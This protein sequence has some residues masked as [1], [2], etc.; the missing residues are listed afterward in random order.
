MNETVK[1]LS[2][3]E[4]AQQIRDDVAAFLEGGPNLKAQSIK[5]AKAVGL[6]LERVSAQWDEAE[7]YLLLTPPAPRKPK[8]IEPLTALPTKD[9]GWGKRRSLAPV[10]ATL[11]IWYLH[12]LRLQRLKLHLT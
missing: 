11:F 2:I 6:K 12:N 3:E 7:E 1:A 5:L 10:E 9:E 8:K 4:G